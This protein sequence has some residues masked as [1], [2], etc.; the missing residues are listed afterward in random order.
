MPDREYY[1]DPSPRMAEIRAKYEATSRTLLELARQPDAAAKAGRIV[2]LEQR[3]AKAHGSREDS[4]DVLKSNNHWTR[5]DFDRRGA[6][7]RLDRVLRRRRTR[8]AVGVR[9]LAADGRHRHRG[10]RSKPCRSRRGRSILSLHALDRDAPVLP[11]AFVDERFAFHG[12]VLTGT[13]AL[14]ERWKRAVDATNDALGDAVG[15]LY[16]DKYFPPAE[17]AACGRRW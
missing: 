1:L 14:R 6:R 9:R 11:K 3:I 16:V 13:P 12:R 15:K 2:A 17:K 8:R 10:A 4:D 5:G 7:P